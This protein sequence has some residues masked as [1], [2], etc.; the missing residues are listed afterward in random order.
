VALRP[1]CAASGYPCVKVHL[2]MLAW[3]GLAWPGLARRAL[4]H[5][6]GLLTPSLL[7]RRCG[8]LYAASTLIADRRCGCGHQHLNESAL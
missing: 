1:S 8:A 5:H 4:I 6:P 3:P 2:R 7:A